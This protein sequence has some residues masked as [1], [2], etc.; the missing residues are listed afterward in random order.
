MVTTIEAH[1]TGSIPN[2]NCQPNTTFPN[3]KIY[4]IDNCILTQ[5]FHQWDLSSVKFLLNRM[6]MKAGVGIT[7]NCIFIAKNRKQDMGTQTDLE[8]EMELSPLRKLRFRY[9]KKGTKRRRNLTTYPI[10]QK[11]PKNSTI[12]M[13]LYY[14]QQREKRTSAMICD[15]NAD[16]SYP[17][18]SS[19]PAKSQT[20]T[21]RSPKI[22]LLSEQKLWIISR[23]LIQQ[24]QVQIKIFV[25]KR[26]C[27]QIQPA[28]FDDHRAITQNARRTYT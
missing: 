26:D 21:F 15:M 2:T 3:E 8:Q 7:Y 1:Q 16:E 28:R 5:I 23:E 25:T 24:M 27:I 10:N 6:A 14:R 17:P 12:P 22:L 20:I 18:T 9:P 4:S 11:R 13:I 19:R